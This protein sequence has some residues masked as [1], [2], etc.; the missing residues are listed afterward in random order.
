M[1]RKFDINVHPCFNEKPNN[2]YRLHLPIAPKCNISC[3]YCVR[4]N[5]CANESRPGVTSKIMS[6]DEAFE[7]YKM[8][9]NKSNGLLSVVGIAGPG[10]SLA[11]WEETYELLLRIRQDDNNIGLCLSTNGLLLPQYVKH[12]HDLKL[13]ALTVTVNSL[14]CAIGEKIYNYVSYNHR[15]YTGINGAEIL[16]NNQWE[17]ITK[18]SNNGIPIKIN[19]VLIDG[20]NNDEIIKIAS[21][22]KECN[23]MIQNIIPY[24]HVDGTSFTQNNTPS[25]EKVEKYRE[26]A[27]N[28]ILQM[29]HCNKC[30]A[31]AFGSLK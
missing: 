10:D 11:N 26:I 12:L 7:Y 19:T 6:I 15:I 23:C 28:H 27:Q 14:D 5:D 22:A 16:F 24:V 8:C 2:F 20:I 13:S 29:H 1:A 3:K 31:D 17:G 4:K 25:C 18:A 9:K 30:R 21:K